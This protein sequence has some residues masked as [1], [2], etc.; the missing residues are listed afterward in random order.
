VDRVPIIPR[1]HRGADMGR[2]FL[3]II[4]VAF[5]PG[6]RRSGSTNQFA[7]TV[8]I[9]GSEIS[10][11]NSLDAQSR[12]KP[13]AFLRHPR[14]GHVQALH[15][16]STAA[17]RG[18]SHRYAQSVSRPYQ[19]CGNRSWWCSRWRL[20]RPP[21]GFST[22]HFPSTFLPVEDQAIFLSSSSR[23]RMARRFSARTSSPRKVRDKIVQAT[24]GR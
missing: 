21:P 3:F 8:A 16:G 6:R 19:V 10:A 23:C 22:A 11:F 15:L 12:A 1:T 24:T 4:P 9:L 2:L 5:I 20:A 7:L 17:S 13:R 14:R 18:L